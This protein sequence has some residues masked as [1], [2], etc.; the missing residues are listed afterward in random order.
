V[1][2]RTLLLGVDGGGTRCRALLCSASGEKF[3]EAA[4]GPANIRFGVEQSFASVLQATTQCL[5]EANLSPRDFGRIVAC[6]ALAGASEPSYLA[7]AQA[8]KHPFRK[9]VFVTDAQA[10]CVGAHGGQDGGIIIVG[11]G[12]GGWA[13]VNGRHYRVGGWGWLISDEGSGAWLGSEALRRTLW[14]HDGRIRWTGLLTSLFVKFQSDPHAIVRWM[15]AAAPRD[16]GSFAPA[17]I[18]HAKCDD[19][20]ATELMQLAGGHIDALAEHLVAFGTERIALAGGLAAYIEPWLSEM[21]RQ[22]LVA[23]LGSALEGALQLA[24]AAAES[25]RNGGIA[26]VAGRRG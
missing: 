18:E 15:T 5:A 17:I 11:T 4:A 21:T 14:A 16:Y 10:A 23:P 6:L 12:S 7:V 19:P 26:S 9:A 25:T 3:A 20:V 2:T 22:H 13:Q 8:Y 1:D 24:K